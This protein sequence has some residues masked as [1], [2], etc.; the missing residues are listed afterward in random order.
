MAGIGSMLGE[1]T[2]AAGPTTTVVAAAT[3]EVSIAISDMFGR[4]GQ[5]F[6]ALSSK[7]ATVH[8]EFVSLLNVGAAAYLNTE[9][10][11]AQQSLVN[12]M[13]AP[14]PIGA[15]VVANTVAA[16]TDPILGGLSPIFVGGTGG[17][18]WAA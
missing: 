10:A 15:S 18:F 14:A 9:I 7:A 8:N 6:Q 17:G 3:D 1:A 16:A 2:A 13:N 12:A 11:N 4:Y 5:Q